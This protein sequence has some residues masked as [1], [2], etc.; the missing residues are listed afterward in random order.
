MSIWENG[1]LISIWTPI[2]KRQNGEAKYRRANYDLLKWAKTA[3]TI[4]ETYIV[5][6]GNRISSNAAALQD[7]QY[8]M[9][10]GFYS[11]ERRVIEP[12]EADGTKDSWD[13]LHTFGYV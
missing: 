9:E 3:S 1:K 5:P 11:L 7:A 10:F 6:L 13:S 12:H 2:G 8:G 4:E